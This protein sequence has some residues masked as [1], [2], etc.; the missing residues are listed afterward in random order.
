VV[1]TAIFKYEI[2]EKPFL[3]L[4]DFKL[5]SWTNEHIDKLR[6]SNLLIGT[7]QSDKKF[8]MKSLDLESLIAYAN[9]LHSLIAIFFKEDDNF[10]ISSLKDLNI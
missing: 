6:D 8:T 3:D 10:K 1:N 9:Y 4:Y 2:K 7:F 5:N